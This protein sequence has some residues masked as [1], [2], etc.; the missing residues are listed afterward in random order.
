MAPIQGTHHV[1]Q[2]KKASR[3]DEISGD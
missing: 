2:K 3:E 1:M